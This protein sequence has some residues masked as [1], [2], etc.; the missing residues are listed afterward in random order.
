MTVKLQ[1][2]HHLE[3]LSFKGGC[4][5]SSE[6]T[7]VKMPHC[8]KSH[9]TAHLSLSS[10]F[11]LFLSGLFTQVLLYMQTH[12]L[13][14]GVQWLSGRMLDLR[15]RGPCSNLTRSTML[16][17]CTRHYIIYP[18]CLVLVQPRKMST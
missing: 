14:L 1:T 10:L 12:P 5:G 6:S 15:S 9:D 11:C 4:R 17:P 13:Y 8:W 18:H 7:L 16:C 3:F 2:E